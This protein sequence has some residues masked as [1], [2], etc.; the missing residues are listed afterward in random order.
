M[1]DLNRWYCSTFCLQTVSFTADKTKYQLIP[2]S[3]TKGEK[4]RCVL[5]DKYTECYLA[6]V[7]NSNKADRI[8]LNHEPVIDRYY[9]REK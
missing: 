1:V 2:M 9:L 3:Y 7:P 5:C 8:C 4:H 6:S